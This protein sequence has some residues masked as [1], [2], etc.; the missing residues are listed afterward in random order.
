[1]KAKGRIRFFFEEVNIPGFSQAKVR[2]WILQTCRAEEKGMGDISIIFCNDAYLQ[3][4]NLDYLNHEELTDV[5]TFDYQDMFGHVSGDV[6]ISIDRV[7]E[8]AEIY[9]TTFLNELH[10]VI[11]HGVLHLLGFSDH[12]P[13]LKA[14]MAG[15]ENYYLSLLA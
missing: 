7:K 8:N 11:I 10:R 2:E 1:M 5:I 13:A 15:K 6:F 12:E 3:K 4:M 9:Q 14:L